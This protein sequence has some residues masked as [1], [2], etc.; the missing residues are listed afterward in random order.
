MQRRL[1]LNMIL[2]VAAGLLGLLVWQAQP[3][4]FSPLTPLSPAS[5]ERIEISDL[6]GRQ[7]ELWKQAG[8]WRS[9]SAITNQQRIS[10]LLSICDTPSLEHFTAPSDLTPFGL[11][12]APIRLN[13][14]G[15][16]LEFGATDPVN[17]WRYVRIGEQIHLIAD[18][19]Y[20]HLTAPLPDWLEPP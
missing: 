17:G 9:G 3:P 5:V 20:H 12:P 6:S 10:Q 7:I 8:V 13:L 11:D 15:Q 16:T 1:W 14:N 19:F 18:G 2:L 4:G